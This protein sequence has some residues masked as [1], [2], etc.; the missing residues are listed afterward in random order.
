[1][2]P[3]KGA[4]AEEVV[5]PGNI[6]PFIDSPIYARTNGYLKKWY[7]DIGTHVK[8][9]QLLAEIDTP[10]VDQTASGRKIGLGDRGGQR[11]AGPDLLP[12][13]TRI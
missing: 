4:N 10:E 11:K 9:G 1:M 13:A 6:Q 5:I 3:R 12:L 8:A 7:M 2:Q